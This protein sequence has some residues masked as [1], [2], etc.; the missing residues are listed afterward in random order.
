VDIEKLDVFGVAMVALEAMLFNS[1][2]RYYLT[3]DS[4]F[5][6]AYDERRFRSDF[7]ELQQIYPTALTT[8]I[9]KMSAADPKQRLSF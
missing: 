4:E 1:P 3:Q 7:R 8:L 6:L 2:R 5:A 9:L